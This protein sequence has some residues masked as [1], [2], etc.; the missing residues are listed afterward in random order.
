MTSLIQSKNK[1]DIHRDV[2]IWLIHPDFITFLC[3]T[4]QENLI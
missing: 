1:F 3:F 4:F 2:I